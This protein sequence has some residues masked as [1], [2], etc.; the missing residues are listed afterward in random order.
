MRLKIF[1]KSGKTNDVLI[2][3]FKGTNSYSYINLTKG[4]ICP[5]IFSSIQ[6]ALEDL[7]K[8]NN[9]KWYI[10]LPYKGEI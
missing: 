6:E 1:Y 5:C 10:Q 7:K 3:P 9:I 4:H 2:L 8:Y